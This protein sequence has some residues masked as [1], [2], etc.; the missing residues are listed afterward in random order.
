MKPF[1]FSVYLTCLIST[2]LFAASVS[3]ED[4]KAVFDSNCIAC[5]IN[6]GNI[7]DP[8]KTLSKKH[9]EKLVDE[10]GKYQGVPLADAVYKLLKE[11]VKGTAMMSFERLGEDKI[12]AVRDYVIQQAETGWPE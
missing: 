11:G 4:G 6:G 5:H 8:T 1:V 2:L 10:G 7:V 12:K 9:L 3:A